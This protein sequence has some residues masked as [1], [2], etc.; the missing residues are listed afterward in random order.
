[1][2][3]SFDFL[4]CSLSISN[5]RKTC[6]ETLHVITWCVVFFNKTFS[7]IWIWSQASIVL[8]FF[9]I[10]GQTWTPFFYKIVL[11][12]KSVYLIDPVF[13]N[14]TFGDTWTLTLPTRTLSDDFRGFS[15]DFQEYSKYFP[16]I[17]ANFRT[18][19]KTIRFS[20]NFQDIFDHF[21]TVNVISPGR[22][23][24]PI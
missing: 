12:R 11:I 4:L 22:W 1:M 7:Y 21:R 10:F 24:V 17:S 8:S 16:I 14:W 18:L 19:P 2:G 3:Q 20:M 15:G 6:K 23:T 9:L 13:L 5:C